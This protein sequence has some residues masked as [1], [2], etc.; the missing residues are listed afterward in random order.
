M[1]L[2]EPSDNPFRASFGKLMIAGRVRLDR[3][4]PCR[5]GT[6]GTIISM[7]SRPSPLLLCG[8]LDRERRPRHADKESTGG[9]ALSFMQRRH[10][11]RCDHL[12]EGTRRVVSKREELKGRLR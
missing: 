7:S 3:Q 12:G 2:V 1:P 9:N 8:Q 4:E 6:P 5:D 10:R 11:R